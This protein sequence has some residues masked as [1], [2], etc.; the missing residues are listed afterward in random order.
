MKYTVK[1]VNASGA[2]IVFGEHTADSIEIESGH[3]TLL[4]DGE[5]VH[6]YAPGH[7]SSVVSTRTSRREKE[8]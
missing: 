6:A 5:L 8:E 1:L 2:G 4:R 7:W 3:L